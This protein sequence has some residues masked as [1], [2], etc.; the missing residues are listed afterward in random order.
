MSHNTSIS[1]YCRNICQSTVITV[2]QQVK[3]LT[4]LKQLVQST[5]NSSISH[6]LMLI[7]KQQ[8]DTI[9]Q[10]WRRSDKSEHNRT[11]RA[12]SDN[13]TISTAS[14]VSTSSSIVET[15]VNQL[16]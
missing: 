6:H 9:G 11:K 8:T 1:Q 16:S 7:E 3:Q 13:Q 2:N 4:Q 15:F 12:Q 10:K 14:T 5:H